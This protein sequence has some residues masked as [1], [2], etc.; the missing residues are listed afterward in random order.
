MATP[1][2]GVIA[3]SISAAVVPKAKFLAITAYG[4]ASPRIEIEGFAIPTILN[5]LLRAGDDA[6][7]WRAE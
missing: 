3:L 2:T 6:D 7:P 1:P 5:W 4:P